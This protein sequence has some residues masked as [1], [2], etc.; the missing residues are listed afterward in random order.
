[1][2]TI[3]IDNEFRCHVANDG[4]MTAIETDF[5]NDKCDEFIEGY[6]FVPVGETWTR[7]DGMV[8]KGKMIA[9][10][11]SYQKLAAAQQE[12]EMVL[13]EEYKDCFKLLGVEV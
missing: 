10:Y 2:R 9:P 3:Y 11:K 8:F 1:M 7:S 4:T 6:R 5:F 13:F 12:Y